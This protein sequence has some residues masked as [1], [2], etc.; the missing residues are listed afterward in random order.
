MF[1]VII[2]A[3]IACGIAWWILEARSGEP[4]TATAATPP[5]PAEQVPAQ[6]TAQA[7][8]IETAPAT[9]TATIET[10]IRSTPPPGWKQSTTAPAPAPELA[11]LPA[12]APPIVTTPAAPATGYN[13]FQ[14][15]SNLVQQARLLLSEGNPVAARS[16]LSDALIN[17]TLPPADAEEARFML[18]AINDRLVFSSEITPDDPFTLRYT[19]QP[20]DSLAKIIKN[21]GLQV[22]WRFLQRINGL[23]RPEHIRVGQK[24]KIIT[25]PFHAEIDRENHRLDLYLGDG[26]NRVFV[27]DFLVGLGE[28]DCTPSGLFRVR[29]NSKL[30]NPPWTNPRSRKHFSANDPLNPIGEYW[31]GLEGIQDHNAQEAGFGMHGTIDPDSIG[32]NESMGCV[33]LNTGEIDLVYEV[34]TEGVSTVW[35]SERTATVGIPGG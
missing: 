13:T 19:V 17:R 21:L 9:R 20:G 7:P 18:T 28:Y 27:R 6:A 24:L 31:M 5:S 33:R 11:A 35:V 22:D 4:A 8:V 23:Q 1:A 16:V 34:L 25:G 15:Q 2:V 29:R 10:T 32:R 14:A 26:M 12:A 30:V 3:V